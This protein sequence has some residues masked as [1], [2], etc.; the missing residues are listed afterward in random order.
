MANRI[1]THKAYQVRDRGENKK[2]IWT[3]IGVGWENKDGS[4]SLS[5][6]SVPLDGKIQVRV[7]EIKDANSNE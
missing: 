4:I 6:N 1:P 2:S 5:L 3:E 7:F